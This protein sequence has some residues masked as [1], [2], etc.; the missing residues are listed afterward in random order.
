MKTL[1]SCLLAATLMTACNST[2]DYVANRA[3]DF[4]DILRAKVMAGKGA[5]LY[6]NATEYLHAGYL[7][8]DDISSAGIANRD[9]GTW[10][11]SSDAWGLLLGRYNEAVEG[12]YYSGTYGYTFDDGLGFE[13]ADKDNWMDMLEFRAAL[14]LGVGVDLELRTGEVI[15]FVLGLFTLDLAGDDR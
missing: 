1:L 12:G 3:G 7:Y 2:N 13:R 5:G 10:N 15:D 11:E 9:A 4:T 6:V 8:T 14:M